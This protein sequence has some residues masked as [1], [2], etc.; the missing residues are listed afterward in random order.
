MFGDRSPWARATAG[1]H[2]NR[3]LDV[4]RRSSFGL[5]AVGLLVVGLLSSAPAA[6]SPTATPER[7]PAFAPGD[8]CSTTPQSWVAGSV[9]LCRGTLVYSDY[10]H[11]DYGA[12]TGAT[13]TTSRTSSLAPTGG[14]QTYPVA[15]HDAT[16]DLVRL[17]LRIEG[18]ELVVEG[19]LNALF[20]PTQTTLGIAIDTDNN[21]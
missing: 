13:N 9:D 4:S 15:G 1:T 3:G 10:V 12:D 21:A 19:L 2:S 7:V 20:T 8:E 11:D 17:T 16:A 14:D 6:A 18:N 5:S